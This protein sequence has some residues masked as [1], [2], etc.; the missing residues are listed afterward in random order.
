MMTHFGEWLTYVASIDFIENI[1]EKQ[2]L[3][4]SRTAVSILMVV[5]I[6]PNVVM[7][8]LG[9]TMAD[10]LDRRHVMMGLDI[11]GATCA[12]LFLYAYQQESIPFLY[13]A[14]TV[15]QCL[16][17]LYAPSHSAMVPQ[18]VQSDAELQI[19]TTL[20][21]FTWSAM[22]AFGAAFSGLIVEVLGIKMCFMIDGMTYVMSALCLG[23]VRGSFRVDDIPKEK[24]FTTTKDDDDDE[25]LRNPS[26]LLGSIR[27]TCDMIMEGGRYIQSSYFAALI[28]LK[29]MAAIPYGACDVINVGFSEDESNMSF[30]M[31][32]NEKLGILFSLVGVGC[33]LG[34]LVADRWV[35]VEQPKTLQVSCIVGF[36]LSIVGYFGWA[37]IHQFWSL[38]IFST[39]R[40]AGSSIIWIHSTLMLQKFTA[41]QMMG[42]VLAADYAIALFFEAAGAYICGVFMDHHPSWTPYNVSLVLAVVS[43]LTTTYWILFHLS[44]RGACRFIDPNI[45]VEIDVDLEVDETSAQLKSN[46]TNKLL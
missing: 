14:T 39:I 4:T 8:A 7:S 34:P 23:F 33:L 13:L 15:Q 38:C 44:G 28:F 17:G 11:G 21:G 10:C 3:P 22:Q 19:A 25:V 5:R 40:A 41:L 32:P 6:L 31:S 30:Q 9:G 12:G 20:E 27:Q 46:R 35:Q 36:V 26:S 43:T 16:A 42:R 18:L 1:R 45:T 24:E 2:G 37:T 29:G